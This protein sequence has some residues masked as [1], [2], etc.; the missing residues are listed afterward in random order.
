MHLINIPNTCSCEITR[1][2]KKDY[3]GCS[4]IGDDRFIIIRKYTHGLLVR[5]VFILFTYFYFLNVC[6]FASCYL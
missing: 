4:R 1:C 3:T 5:R 6:L 2:V